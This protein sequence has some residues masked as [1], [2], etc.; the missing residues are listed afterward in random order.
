MDNYTINRRCC[1]D[2]TVHFLV[3]VATGIA[4]TIVIVN[5]YQKLSRLLHLS[6]KDE[7]T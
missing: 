5:N 3:T 1:C 7:T 2:S 6:T 4:A